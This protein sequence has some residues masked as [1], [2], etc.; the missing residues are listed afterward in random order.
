MFSSLKQPH[1]EVLQKDE[2][3][4]LH[5]TILDFQKRVRARLSN[6]Y[7][8]LESGRHP[9]TRKVARVLFMALEH[10]SFHTEVWVFI[11]VFWFYSQHE[12]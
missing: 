1:S 11:L 7:A 4:P 2:V 3:W 9:L 8:E 5:S 10:G 6:L 12:L